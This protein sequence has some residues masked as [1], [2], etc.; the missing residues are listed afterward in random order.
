MKHT[1]NKLFKILSIACL[2][3]ARGGLVVVAFVEMSLLHEYEGDDLDVA[4][5][6][7]SPLDLPGLVV[8]EFVGPERVLVFCVRALRHLHVHD[9][10]PR[11]VLADD[12]LRV[13]LVARVIDRGTH[14]HGARP[15]VDAS[16]LD[17]LFD[18]P[19]HRR[20]RLLVDDFA[21]LSESVLANRLQVVEGSA[22]E[23]VLPVLQFV[24]VVDD[25]DLLGDDCPV[26][27]QFDELH[28]RALDLRE[29]AGDLVLVAGLQKTA[30]FVGRSFFNRQVLAKVL[31]SGRNPPVQQNGDDLPMAVVSSAVH[32]SA[33]VSFEVDRASHLQNH[34]H[35][36]DVA[37]SHSMIKRR[38]VSNI[39][40]K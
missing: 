30:D 21:F 40:I 12:F 34:G 18:V 37:R 1:V 15:V 6:L 20:K 38:I 33:L 31:D 5:V 25:D 13:D 3:Q 26:L 35:N 24:G 8:L 14:E 4:T 36:I 11:D 16:E 17:S 23:G 28:V 19:V 27:L 22:V 7:D 29:Q 10:H 32:G 2:H 9:W 39:L